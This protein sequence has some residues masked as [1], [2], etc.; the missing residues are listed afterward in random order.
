MWFDCHECPPLFDGSPRD[1][2]VKKYRADD[3]VTCPHYGT[4]YETDGD[5]GWGFCDFWT[6]PNESQTSL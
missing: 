5:F 2:E 4:E 3:N 6:V 1:F